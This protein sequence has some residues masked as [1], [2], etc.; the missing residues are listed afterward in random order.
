[1]DRHCFIHDTHIK[2]IRLVNLNDARDRA[3]YSSK[4]PVNSCFCLWRWSPFTIT[5]MPGGTF[6]LPSPCPVWNSVL[7]VLQRIH[8]FFPETNI[9]IYM[10]VCIYIYIHT[11]THIYTHTHTHIYVYIYTHTHI[12]IHIHTHTYIC[13][14]IYTHTHTNVH[15]ERESAHWCH[16]PSTHL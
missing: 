1:M 9:Y 3:V 14:Y 2:G 7:T 11:H 16:R 10:Y 15:R 12:Y 5:I 13:V 6:M 8:I 4:H